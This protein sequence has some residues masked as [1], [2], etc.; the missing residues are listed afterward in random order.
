MQ[1]CDLILR[2]AE[3]IDGTGGAVQR[4][5]VAVD[6]GMICGIGPCDGWRADREIDVA[7]LVIAPGF[8]DV[9]THDDW[10]VLA[11][12]EIPFKITQGVTTVV[13]G[14]C[15]IS[16]APFAPRDGLP[17]PFGVIPGI[18]EHSHSSVEAYAGAVA[19]TRP[20]VNVRLLVGHSVLWAVAMTGD[21]E[22]PATSEETA[23]MAEVLDVA[24][25]QGAGG[26]PAGWITRRRCRPMG[27]N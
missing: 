21:L 19:A 25:Q 23:R 2:G 1:S 6:R 12:P 13:A 8:I 16:A 5:D 26:C 15:G 27:R 14:N 11:T 9:H 24:L 18:A 20:A 22:R 17:A 4:A 10:A 3:V 7:G